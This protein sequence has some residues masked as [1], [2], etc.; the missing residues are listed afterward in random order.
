M[1]PVSDGRTRARVEESKRLAR[2]HTSCLVARV[3]WCHADPWRTAA[4]SYPAVSYPAIQRATRALARL[5][6]ACRVWRYTETVL[7]F[8]H[9]RLL[10]LWRYK[11]V[12][13]AGPLH[14][15]RA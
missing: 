11:R 8:L 2:R 4:I 7:R 15:H 13:F 12:R 1:M 3:S 10:T 9:T 6:S 14:R 5:D